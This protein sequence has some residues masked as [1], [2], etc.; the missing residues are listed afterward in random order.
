MP[1][2]LG[3]CN[4]RA[5]TAA[6]EDA[7]PLVVVIQSLTLFRH[8]EQRLLGAL[9]PNTYGTYE[10]RFPMDRAKA[11]QRRCHNCSCG[12]RAVERLAG[13]CT[14]NRDYP[15]RANRGSSKYFMTINC[16]YTTTRGARMFPDGLP[17]RMQFA[18]GYINT[19]RISYL[20]ILFRR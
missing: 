10:C 15:N 19:L 1:L 7:V 8:L 3:T 14:Q 17:L 13:C 16:V 20:Y 5:G 12:T 18:N 9:G 4:T 2:I 11:S 6:W